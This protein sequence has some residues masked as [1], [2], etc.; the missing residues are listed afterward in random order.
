MST[1]LKLFSGNEFLGGRHVA[2]VIRTEACKL[3]TDNPKSMVFLDFDGVRGVSHSFSD[4]LLS[5]LSDLL[6]PD[7]SRHVFIVNCDDTVKKDL[8]SV[9]RLHDLNQPTFETPKE[10]CFC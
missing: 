4:E 6:G 5:P 9:A 8:Q 10:L 2:F 7:V 3:L 1:T